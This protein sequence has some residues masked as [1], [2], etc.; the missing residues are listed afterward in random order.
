MTVRPNYVTFL[1]VLC[2]C[3]HKGLVED[4]YKYFRLMEKTHKIKPMM[5]HYGAMVDILGRAWRLNEAYE[6][7]KRMPFESD[8]FVWRTLL[9]ACSIHHE[10]DDKGLGEKVKKILIEIDLKRSDNLVIVANRF[11][12]KIEKYLPYFGRIVSLNPNN[13]L[14]SRTKSSSFPILYEQ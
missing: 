13:S 1:G 7:I 2:A 10:E 4:E 11:A 9:S 3:S 5:I 14:N 8:A 12:V 6:F